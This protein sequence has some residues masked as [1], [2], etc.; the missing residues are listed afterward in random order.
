MKNL[1]CLKNVALELVRLR[2]RSAEVAVPLKAN[3]FSAFIFAH[4]R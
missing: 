3:T 2:R 4:E 1:L